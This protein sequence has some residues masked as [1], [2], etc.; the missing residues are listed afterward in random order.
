VS[1]GEAVVAAGRGR[2]AATAIAIAKRIAVRLLAGVGV[3]WGAA[4]LSFVALHATAGD[5]AL[6]TVA[7]QGANPTKEVLDQVRRDFGLDKPLYRQYLDYLGR[8]FHGDLGKSYQQRISVSRAIGEQ[9]GQ[10][11]QLALA[12]AAVAVLL[13]V[14]VAVLT[15]RRRPW[16][17]IASGVELT[18]SSTPTFVIGIVLLIIFSFTLKLLPVS[19]NDGIAALVLPT[20]TLA[21]PIGAVLT[22]VLRSELEEVL[23]QPFILTARSRGMRDTA[24][25]LR[26]ALRHA[27]VQIVTMSGFVVGGLLGGAVITETLFVRQGVGQLMLSAVTTK[28][29]PMVLGLVVFAA[30]VYVVVNLLVDIGYTLIDPR[31]VTR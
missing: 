10:T 6:S 13:A 24:V 9:L 22:Q 3:L 20:L 31:L 4:T 18:L 30:F 11:V 23:E 28:D 17:S 19:G 1:A 25:R 27:L 16:R 26:H 14:T 21:L 5:A 2:S 7:G 15:A 8:L 12:A 29:I